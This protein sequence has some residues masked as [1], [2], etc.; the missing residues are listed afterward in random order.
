MKRSSVRTVVM[1]PLPFGV[2]ARLTSGVMGRRRIFVMG[3]RR[4]VVM[5]RRRIL[6]M[7]RRRI[8]VMAR[9]RIFVMA[10]LVRATYRRTVLAGVARMS[11][12]MMSIACRH[13]HTPLSSS[14]GL[15]RGPAAARRA[16]GAAHHR[17]NVV[18]L[19]LGSSPG[20]TTR[21]PGKSFGAR[22]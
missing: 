2:M 9:R 10:R 5:A 18:R 12:A 14:S 11:R 1:A 3:R 21:A 22:P 8:F 6:V 7:G 16:P 17:S 4:I 20:M 15:T 13:A 19:M